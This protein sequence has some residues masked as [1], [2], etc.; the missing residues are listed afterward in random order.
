MITEK[1]TVLLGSKEVINEL[2]TYEAIEI[3]KDILKI[4]EVWRRNKTPLIQ[5]DTR[6]SEQAKILY[7][8]LDLPEFIFDSED[9][10]EFCHRNG[11]ESGELCS[12]E[13]F[14]TANDRCF[15]CEI[16][17]HMGI[18]GGYHLFNKE[19]PRDSDI[20]MYESENF[21]VKVELGTLKKGMLMI[22]PKEHILSAA[23]IPDEQMEEYREVCEDTEFLLKVIYGDKTVLFF[24]HGSAPDGI[25]SHKR[26]IVHAHVHVAWD[27]VFPKKFI[28]MVC[29]KPSTLEA[30]RGTKYLSYQEGTKGQLL[31]VNDPEVY[32]QRQ[33]PRQVIG[34]L[35]GIPNYKTNWRTEP[36]DENMTETFRDFYKFLSENRNFLSERIVKNTEGFVK[37]YELRFLNN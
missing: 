1:R 34:I 29:L 23:M 30:L 37:G 17:G 15:L 26:S 36:F 20:I 4:E 9:F 31:A 21:F 25:S 12:G 35:E 13:K 28:D 8:T 16:A 6:V 11:I 24:E 19:T 14:N 5:K 2:G 3:I 7:P 27:V 22:N 33:Y 32:V 10:I 18:E